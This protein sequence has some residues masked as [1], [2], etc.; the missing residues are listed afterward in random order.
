MTFPLGTRA[1]YDRVTRPSA[2]RRALSI[3]R[4]FASVLPLT[5]GTTQRPCAGVLA[6]GNLGSS[7]GEPIHGG[8][9]SV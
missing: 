9:A 4:A 6:P 3:A 2:H 5:F 8:E 1:E 7:G